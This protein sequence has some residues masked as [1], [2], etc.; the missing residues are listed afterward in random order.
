MIDITR[1]VGHH[2]ATTR[3]Q[4]FGNQRPSAVKTMSVWANSHIFE[5]TA[6]EQ[7]QDT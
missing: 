5:G 3:L 4:A 6:L 2:L 7:N 1:C